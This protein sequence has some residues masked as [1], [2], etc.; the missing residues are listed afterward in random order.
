MPKAAQYR[1]SWNAEQQAYEL[2]EHP[3]G[4][5]LTVTDGEQ[6]WFAWLDTIPSFTFWGKL[7]QLTVRKESRQWDEG[8]WYAYRRVGPKLTKKYLGRTADLTLA[9][10][11]ETAALLSG[12]EVS[13]PR[14]MQRYVATLLSAFGAQPSTP[15]PGP[16]R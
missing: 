16:A 6:A 7:G 11:E 4:H 9:R 14:S 1:L 3:G 8:Y 10:L 12:A 5:L 13:P 2:R 15:A